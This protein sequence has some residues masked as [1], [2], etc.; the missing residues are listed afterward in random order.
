MQPIFLWWVFF[1]QVVGKRRDPHCY[2]SPYCYASWIYVVHSC[3][4]LPPRPTNVN[5]NRDLTDSDRLRFQLT[6]VFHGFCPKCVWGAC[7]RRPKVFTIVRGA[8]HRRPKVS[9][10]EPQS[11][12]A[13]NNC[14]NQAPELI[15]MRLQSLVYGLSTSLPPLPPQIPSVDI[16]FAPQ[17]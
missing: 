10:L 5:W 9:I 11:Q 12:T 8:C 16:L 14:R 1:F 2:A 7:H 13:A 15:T 4:Q 17:I 6:F 3:C